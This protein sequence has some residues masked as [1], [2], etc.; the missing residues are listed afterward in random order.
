MHKVALGA[1]VLAF[2]VLSASAAFAQMKVTSDDVKDKGV[3][4]KGMEANVFGCDGGNMS[5]SLKWTGAPEG[6]KS[7][8]IM[9]F[10][11]DAPTGPPPNGRRG[12]WHW[13]A[14]NI[15]ASTT[16]IP[17][18]AGDV[19]AKLMPD[20]VIQSRNS[21]GFDGF[22]GMCPPQGDGPHH[23]MLTVYA[24]DEDKLQFAKDDMISP[25]VVGFETH[26]HSKGTAS[27]NWTYSRPAEK[28]K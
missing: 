6:T 28:K 27:L 21:Y 1:V 12:F 19:K 5:P 7:F 23:Y 4:P 3:S 2:G 24:V 25:E 18:N 14:F 22:G 9:L 8:A 16:S 10:D 11:P 13:I 17:K 20:G 26:F 15:P